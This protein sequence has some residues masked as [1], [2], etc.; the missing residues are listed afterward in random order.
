MFKSLTVFIL[1]GMLL[2]TAGNVSSAIIDTA[3]TAVYWGGYFDSLNCIQETSDNGFIMTGLTRA[4]GES[5]G[6]VKLIKTDANGM[7][8]WDKTIGDT[9]YECGFH[10]METYDGGYLVSAQSSI[11]GDGSGGVWIIKT[12]NAGDT[13]W[14]YG[15][16][17]EG[18]NGFPIDAIQTVD[19]GYAITGV[20]NYSGKF[21][22]AFVLLLDKDGNYVTTEHY[23]DDHYQGAYFI[24]QMPDSGFIICGQYDNYYT[25]SYDFWALRLNKLLGVVWDSTYALT[26]YY[27]MVYGACRVDD[28]IN[29][30]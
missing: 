22:D 23:G 19:S 3:W 10:V 2:L 29:A 5:Q 8:E 30:E 27:D 6:D 1:L 16:A 7:V 28:G 26:D 17:P 21:N 4:M 25:T 15:F 11:I 20:F 12:D 13:L 14:T 9:Y 24:T 18:R